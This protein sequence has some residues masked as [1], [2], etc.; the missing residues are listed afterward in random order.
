MGDMHIEPITDVHVSSLIATCGMCGNDIEIDYDALDHEAGRVDPAHDF[1]DCSECGN[2]YDAQAATFSAYIETTRPDPAQD[3]DKM[4]RA[5]ERMAVLIS[6]KSKQAQVIGPAVHHGIEDPLQL[7]VSWEDVMHC[8]RA[9]LSD[10]PTTEK[11][12]K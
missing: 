8:F 4:A 10:S 6:E 2:L 7:Y 12:T 3:A 11:T 1:R 5:A 9:A